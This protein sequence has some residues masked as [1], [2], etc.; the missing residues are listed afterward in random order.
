[1]SDEEDTTVLLSGKNEDHEKVSAALVVQQPV[2]IS[3]SNVTHVAFRSDIALLLTS[4]VTVFGGLAFGYDM[5]I[6]TNIISQIKDT[7]E[8]TCMEQYMISSTWFIGALI[9]SF[10]GG[11]SELDLKSLCIELNPSSSSDKLNTLL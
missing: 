10:V 11:T 4:L 6:G 8:L 1:M 9:A 3:G 2:N 5:G 7:Y